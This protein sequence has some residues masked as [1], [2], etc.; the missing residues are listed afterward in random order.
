MKR[1]TLRAMVGVAAAVLAVGACSGGKSAHKGQLM[2]AL[3]TDMSIPDDVSHVRI[4]VFKNGG[5][6]FD[7]KYRVGPD[8]EEIPATLGIIASDNSEDTTEVRVLSYQGATVRTLNRAVTTIPQDRIATLRIPI[9]WLCDGQVK[10]TDGVPD[11]Y[12]S[13]CKNPD[14][15]CVAGEC[16]K[17]RVDPETLPDFRSQDVTGGA[18]DPTRGLCF[19]TIPCLESGRDVVPDAACTVSVPRNEAESLNVGLRLAP[20][21]A[22]ICSAQ[23]TCY[24]PLDRSEGAGWRI[25]PGA[26]EPARVQLPPAVCTKLASGDALAVRVSSACVTKT[27]QNPTCGPWTSVGTRN[28]DTGPTPAGSGGSGGNGATGGM[29]GMG[30]VGQNPDPSGQCPALFAATPQ[31][32]SQNPE[33]DRFAKLSVEFSRNANRVRTDVGMACAGIRQRLT[34][35]AT[36]FAGP[37][38]TDAELT[39]S[40][41]AARVAMTAAQEQTAVSLGAGYCRVDALEQLALEQGCATIAGCSFA[42]FTERCDSLLTSCEG[43]CAGACMPSTTALNVACEGRCAGQCNGSCDGSC[44]GPGGNPL[45]AS[46]CRGLCDGTCSGT[47]QGSCMGSACAGTCRGECDG[48][49]TAELCESPLALPACAMTAA[50]QNLAAATAG[51]HQLCVPPSVFVP[52]PTPPELAPAISDNFPRVLQGILQGRGFE[53]ASNYLDGAGRSLQP[54]VTSADTPCFDEARQ[55]IAPTALGLALTVS[56]AQSLVDLLI[57]DGTLSACA[58]SAADDVCAVC[59]KSNC[60]AE[61][62]ACADSATCQ[63]ETTCVQ[64]CSGRGELSAVC[65]QE[66][67]VSAGMLEPSSTALVDCRAQTCSQCGPPTQVCVVTGASGTLLDDFEDQDVVTPLGGWRISNPAGFLGSMTNV[68][69]GAGAS[70]RALGVAGSPDPGLSL[71]FTAC[72]DALGSGGLAFAASAPAATVPVSLTVRVRTR[73][74]EPMERGGNCSTGCGQHFIATVSL[75]AGGFSSQSLPWSSLLNP[76]AEA[77]DLRQIVG[78]DFVIY[79]GVTDQLALDD[80]RF[81]AEP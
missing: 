52:G 45:P 53:R 73:S 28:P 1:A 69:P 71:D 17:V 20:G 6:K 43:T 7:Q 63:E 61:L 79:G 34:G 56:T 65:E 42:A 23:G 32:V 75:P 77:P 10:P 3:Q 14:E 9:Q 27:E 44:I 40:C 25:L 70:R 48:T 36:T 81:T 57:T 8:G 18:E 19:D 58:Q 35:Q 47:C 59:M 74:T 76:L 54:T 51:M 11:S 39:A 55:L 2:L 4:I 30:G 22:G 33:L 60:C 16:R 21:R 5:L 13:S 29:G 38:P 12:D 68:E 80:V 26:G 62:E 78:L 41:N 66:C 72:V 49:V 37:V 15:A 64:N 50:C 24:I 46:D 31:P 67:A